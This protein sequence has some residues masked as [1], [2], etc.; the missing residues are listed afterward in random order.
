[1]VCLGDHG[2][3]TRAER[4]YEGVEDDHYV[5]AKGHQFGMDWRAGPAT[6]PQWPPG[7]SD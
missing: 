7:P 6:E 3:L 2:Q 5:C 4:V 1:M